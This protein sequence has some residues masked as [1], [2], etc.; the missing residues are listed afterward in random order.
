MHSSSS[1][2]PLDGIVAVI[3]AHRTGSF[4]AAAE[5]LGIT[6]GAVSRRV[7]AVEHWLATPLFERRARGVQITPAGQRF[8]A[9]AEQALATI[10][11]SA[12]RWRTPREQPIVRLSIVPSFARLW[13]MQRMIALQGDPADVRVELQLD[14]RASDLNADEADLAVR[15]GSGS[16]KGVRA[17]LLFAERL[18][19]VAAA[20]FAKQ[21]GANAKPD[22]IAQLPL[23]HDSDTRQWRAWLGANG[24]RFRGQA[25]DRRFEDYDLV[26]A[27]CSAGLGIALLRTPLA[28]TY[29]SSGRL[30]QVSKRSI[31]NTQGHYLATRADESRDSVL[32]VAE[33]LESCAAQLRSS[34]E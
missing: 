26:L 6:H 2:P 25:H 29:M 31:P 1:L 24:S 11:N 22:R 10:R 3:A 14:H 8:I 18:Y 33:R 23:L 19:P 13:L 7:Q 12:D 28:D 27:A 20:S 9:T 17:R 5:M 32:K 30:V 4:S 15:Y 34:M 16:W 21:L